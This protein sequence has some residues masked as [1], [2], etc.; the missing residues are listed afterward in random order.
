MNFEKI[1]IPVVSIPLFLV[2]FSFQGESYS[3]ST[4]NEYEMNHNQNQ[5]SVVFIGLDNNLASNVLPAKILMIYNNQTYEGKSVFS[6]YRGDSSFADFQ[7]PKFNITNINTQVINVEIGSELEFKIEDYPQIIRPSYLGVTA[8]KDTEATQII[9]SEEFNQTNSNETN[10]IKIDMNGGNYTLIATATWD[11][12][13]ES[14][15][16]YQLNAFKIN[17]INSIK[18]TVN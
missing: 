13:K 8:Y 15:E 11:G 6:I 18:D 7:K 1:I 16:G 4:F 9:D 14:V 12:E 17:L 2:I 10:K 3:L 5:Y